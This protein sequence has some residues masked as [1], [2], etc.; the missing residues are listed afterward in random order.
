MAHVAPRFAVVTGASSGVGQAIAIKLAQHGWNV[1]AVARRADALQQTL[2]LA[3]AAESRLTAFQCDVT[4]AD[5]VEKMAA[6]VLGKFGS[7]H[8]LV[9]SAGINTPDRSLAN[10]S[11]KTFREVMAVNTTGA[12][13][14][15]QA[16]LPTMCKQQAGTIVNIVS[17]SP[18]QPSTNAGPA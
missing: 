10:L 17:T 7:L 3:K 14:C 4:D 8:A 12:Y 5:A 1:A 15:V 11:L 6:A 9:N 13:L 16:F 18:D 2:A